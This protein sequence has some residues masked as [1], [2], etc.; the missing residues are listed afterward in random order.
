MIQTD[1]PVLA[2]TGITTNMVVTTSTGITAVCELAE[3]GVIT[4]ETVDQAT[5]KPKG[6]KTIQKLK[7]DRLIKKPTAKDKQT[8][9]HQ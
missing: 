3:V 7:T 2:N 9:P 6:V 8:I 4:N 1:A 5:K